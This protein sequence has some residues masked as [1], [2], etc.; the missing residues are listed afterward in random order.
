[1][2]EIQNLMLAAVFGCSCGFMIIG[3]ILTVWDIIEIIK[4]MHKNRRDK[5]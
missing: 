3:L 4:R 2:S 1:M 5:K